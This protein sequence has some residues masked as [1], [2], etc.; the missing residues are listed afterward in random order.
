MSLSEN[1]FS[2][3][4]ILDILNRY[5]KNNPFEKIIDR[6]ET[7][8]DSEQPL[9]SRKNF[10]GHITA[11]AFVLDCT[12]SKI[13]LVQHKNLNKYIQPGGHV[14]QMDES[15]YS[16]ARR[17]LEEETGFTDAVF[18]PFDK[19][20]SDVPIDIDIHTIPENLKKQE[21]EHIHVDFR[22]VFILET[23]NQDKISEEEID[24][25]VWK[26][27]KEFETMGLDTSR[28]VQKINKLLSEERDWLF[29]NKIV[30]TFSLGLKNHNVII[31][32]H[33][34]PDILP[35]IKTLQG[36]VKGLTVIPKP[37]SVSSTILAQIPKE[38]IC[39]IS[40]TELKDELVLQKLLPQNETSLI[41]DIGGYFANEQFVEFNN[42]EKRVL[43]IIEDTENGHQKYEELGN[44]VRLPIVSVARS[45]L[46]QNE[47]DLIGYSVAFYT[48]WVIRKFRR[49]PKYLTCSI[50]GYGKLGKGIAKYLFNQNIKPFIYDSNP[51]RIVEA[52]K[53]GC[54]PATKKE[55]LSNSDLIFSATGNISISQ[56]ELLGIR[57]GCHIASVTSSDDEFGLDQVNPQ[58]SVNFE[59]DFVTKYENENTYWYLINNGNAVNF[60]DR[61]SD[62]VSNFIRLVQAEI[63]CALQKLS[64]E[65]LP[66][67]IQEIGQEDKKRIAQIFINYYTS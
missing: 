32:S 60:I 51:I 21:P 23:D 49:L 1:I 55:I 29:F 66:Y 12:F 17:E 54:I 61:D 57:P 67:G 43:G 18:V 13:L 7:L 16:A 42:K 65:R 62:R 15:I 48:E 10:S 40:R 24:D 9:I 56:D 41:I 8:R 36:L 35:F 11:S 25:V 30:R 3:N 63:L 47:D 64:D 2:K 28:A 45:V 39:S 50:I 31:V 33:I 27:I 19:S 58:F 20:F 59:N 46:K 37:N 53:D 34:V 5:D 38:I 4:Y 6:T 14:D 26:P 52:Y 22:Y 44:S